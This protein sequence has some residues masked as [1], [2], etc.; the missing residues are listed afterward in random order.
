[1]TAIKVPSRSRQRGLAMV[2]L[3][4]VLPLLLFLLL[5]VAEMG[6]AFFQYNTLSKSVR[7]GARYLAAQARSGTGGGVADSAFDEA[8]RLV[9]CGKTACT[10][11]DELLPGMSLSDVN[12]TRTGLEHVTITAQYLYQP[13]VG[14]VL[15]TFGLGGGDIPL[16]FTLRATVTMRML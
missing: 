5:A 11:G 14:A 9:L 4:I 3:A 7:D 10:S 6:R 13:M 8:Q 16:N 12:A 15:P 1:M 2:E